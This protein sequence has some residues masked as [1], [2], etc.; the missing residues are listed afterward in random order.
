MIEA[1]A[2][3]FDGSNNEA[4]V[5]LTSSQNEFERLV[6][7]FCKQPYPTSAE[8]YQDWAEVLDQIASQDDDPI[9]R[10]RA[11][12]SANRATS[13]RA[14]LRDITDLFRFQVPVHIHSSTGYQ[15]IRYKTPGLFANLPGIYTDTISAVDDLDD[16]DAEMI[17]Q[18]VDLEYVKATTQSGRFKCPLARRNLCEAAVRHTPACCMYAIWQSP[19]M[20]TSIL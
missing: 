16:L 20:R 19:R 6:L 17:T 2:R 9:A 7:S 14:V 15:R 4:L 3:L 10:T 8:I 5:G 12:I 13:D 1:L 18:A 11:D